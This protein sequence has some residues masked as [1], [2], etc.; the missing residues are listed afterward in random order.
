[1]ARKVVEISVEP[2]AHA[3]PP[4]RPP[5]PG[6]QRHQQDLA[7]QAGK[8]DLAVC[9]RPPRAGAVGPPPRRNRFPNYR[10]EARVAR[11]SPISLSHTSCHSFQR[12]Q[13]ADASATGTVPGRQAVL[14]LAAEKQRHQSRT[15]SRPALRSQGPWNLW[16]ATVIQRQLPACEI[17]LQLAA[18]L[19][20]RLRARRSAACRRPFFTGCS[21]PVSWRRGHLTMSSLA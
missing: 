6:S 13:H 16:A 5:R 1:M 4:S 20:R 12:R 17:D 9:C 7:F 19:L 3:V 14:L 2:L 18:T 15:G 8:V 11:S 21:T 10:Y